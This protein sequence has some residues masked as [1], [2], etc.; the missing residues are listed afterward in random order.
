[1]MRSTAA[2][3]SAPPAHLGRMIWTFIPT[4]TRGLAPLF[5]LLMFGGIWG[6]RRIWARRDHQ[7]LFCTALVIL[8]GIWVQ[9]W[10]R[11]QYQPAL[12]LADRADGLAVYRVGTMGADWLGSSGLP[13]GSAGDAPPTAV[14]GAALAIVLVSGLAHA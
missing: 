3:A 14:V 7:A 2:T 8:G 5:A 9:L 6:W 11:Q 13:S 12:C 10:L 1:M 4:M